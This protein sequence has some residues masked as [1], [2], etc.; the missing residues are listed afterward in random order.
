MARTLRF[1]VIW[2]PADGGGR[3]GGSGHRRAARPHPRARPAPRRLPHRPGQRREVTHTRCAYRGDPIAFAAHHGEELAE[4]TAAPVRAFLAE[5]A[6]L[7]PASR[8]RKCA[9]VA[10][11]AKWAVRH[12]LL[13]ANPMDRIDTVKV[14]RACPARPRPPTWPG[15]RW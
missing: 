11:F 13:Q 10:S 14:P 7:S 5:L 3:H 9:A 4:R 1:P 2:Q 8:K 15:C 12:D 6:E